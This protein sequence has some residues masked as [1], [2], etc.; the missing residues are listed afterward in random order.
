MFPLHPHPQA[1]ND[2][3]QRAQHRPLVRMH[4]HLNYKRMH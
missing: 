1:H 3:A 4:K 2:C